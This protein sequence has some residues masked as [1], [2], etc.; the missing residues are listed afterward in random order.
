MRTHDAV[1]LE[2]RARH[3]HYEKH[4]PKLEQLKQAYHGR[5]FLF[6]STDGKTGTV[7]PNGAAAA[8]IAD[9]DK[10]ADDLRW[11]STRQRGGI[12]GLHVTAGLKR[13][14]RRHFATESVGELLRHGTD[15]QRNKS[16]WELK[17]NLKLDLRKEPLPENQKLF[18]RLLSED[19]NPAAE[20]VAKMDTV[21]TESEAAAR[22]PRAPR[23]RGRG[24]ERGRGH[25]ANKR[26]MRYTKRRN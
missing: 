18:E 12:Q 16:G 17:L 6:A 11:K 14:L 23:G 10:I 13:G 22:F 1:V 5:T 26:H 15:W 4:V 8:L 3:I 20:Q 24:Q 25:G 9:I 2:Q 21:V 7:D 19:N